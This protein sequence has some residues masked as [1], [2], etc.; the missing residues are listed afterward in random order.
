MEDM[1]EDVLGFPGIVK[2]RE[3]GMSDWDQFW[4]TN[5]QVQYACVDAYVSCLLGLSLGYGDDDDD[6]EDEDEEDD[7]DDE[8]GF[9]YGYDFDGEYLDYDDYCNPLNYNEDW[10]YDPFHCNP[11]N[12]YLSD[13]DQW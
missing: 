11:Y 2:P 3:V 12:F 9:G 5:E 13:S 10:E 8:D 1:A 4:L 7:E 6:G